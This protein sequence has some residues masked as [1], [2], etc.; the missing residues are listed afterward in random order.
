MT[1]TSP[2]NRPRVIALINLKGGTAKTTSTAF[3][4]HALHERGRRV[5]VIDADPQGST[6]EWQ[7]FADWPVPVLA[8]PS[9]TLHRQIWGVVDADRVD[10]VVIDGPPLEEQAGVVNSIL[11]VATDVIV[12]MAPT[13]MEL[14]RVPAVWKAIDDA[15]GAR[16]DD[17]NVWVLLN[18]TVANAGST[19]TIRTTLESSGKQVFATNIPR[20]EDYA[21]AF[22]SPIPLGKTGPDGAF[23][24]GDKPYGGVVDELLAVWR[25]EA[26]VPA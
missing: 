4:A 7:G 23:V 1:S 6:L 15:N 20:L 19:K 2:G 11:R 26:E 9:A 5:K 17:P 10:D 22:S 18:R 16:D 25:A 14:R 24:P 3:L 8:L 21:Q 13:M 12:P